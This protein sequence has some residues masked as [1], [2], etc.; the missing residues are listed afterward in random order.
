MALYLLRHYL[1]CLMQAILRTLENGE[2]YRIT[3]D[4]VSVSMIAD[5]L[6]PTIRKRYDAMCDQMFRDAEIAP[7]PELLAHRISPIR[8]NELLT[9]L[10]PLHFRLFK[11][12]C[13]TLQPE[14]PFHP[15]DAYFR[16]REKRPLRLQ[17]S[18]DALND[19]DAK[20]QEKPELVEAMTEKFYS[21]V[22]QTN[23]IR[24]YNAMD[25]Q[26]GPAWNVIASSFPE[27]YLNSLEN[28]S[29]GDWYTA[30]FVAEPTQAAMWS[31][32]GDSHRGACLKFKTTTLPSGTQALTLKH[33]NAIDGTGTVQY[34]YGP[35]PFQEVR[36]ADRSLIFQ[37]RSGSSSRF[38]NLSSCSSLLIG[39]KNLRICVPLSTSRFSNSLIC[40][41]RADQTFFC[42]RSWTRTVKTSSY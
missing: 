40:W 15:L 8:R 27:V 3:E 36:Y 18:F 22:E 20:H 23:F 7:L 17:A 4:T 30:C 13:T 42:T 6:H 28:L 5:D 24:D 16:N 1:L 11:L 12:V 35:Q 38:L 39:R 21:V 10:W 32:Y 25:Q 34:E 26:H 37:R 19:W 9:L 29:Y 31:I 33:A 14:G 2:D 41:Y